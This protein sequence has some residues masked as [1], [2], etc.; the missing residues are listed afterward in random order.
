M[1]VHT[2]QG[3]HAH[4]RV[5]QAY[6]ALRRSPGYDLRLGTAGKGVQGVGYIPVHAVHELVAVVLRQ[7]PGLM[8]ASGPYEMDESLIHTAAVVGAPVRRHT[9]PDPQRFRVGAPDVVLAHRRSD[10]DVPLGVHRHERDPPSHRD[11]GS[12]HIVAQDHQASEHVS[13]PLVEVVEGVGSAVVNVP[14]Q[15]GIRIT[16]VQQALT[17]ADAFVRQRVYVPVGP[18]T[19]ADHHLPAG[20]EQSVSSHPPDYQR[21]V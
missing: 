12:L 18:A 9:V 17:D 15:H 3:P 4:R 10:V 11:L 19:P 6:V 2:V 20:P 16:I 14:G 21:G 8:V 13:V 7:V 5:L 1:I